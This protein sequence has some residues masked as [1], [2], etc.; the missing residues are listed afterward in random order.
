LISSTEAALTI[1]KR[2]KKRNKKRAFLIEG[3]HLGM[4]LNNVEASDK[5][6]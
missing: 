5:L 1:I 2:C 4:I 3:E 6:I